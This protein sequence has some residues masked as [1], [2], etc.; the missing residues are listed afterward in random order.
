MNRAM[1]A[2][3]FLNIANQQTPAPVKARQRATDRRAQARIDKDQA[4]HERLMKIWCQTQQRQIDDALIGP[5]GSQIAALLAFLKD[6]SLEREAEL[7]DLV[8]TNSW[9]CADADTR[10]LIMRLIA[11][12]LALLRENAGLPPFDDPLPDE[13]PNTFLR[14]REMLR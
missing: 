7:V 4:D 8:Q 5:Y 3:L 1:T 14:I 11:S 2:D 10:Y 9:H 6:L 12:R 13:L